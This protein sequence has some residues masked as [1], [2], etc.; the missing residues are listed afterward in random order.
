MPLLQKQ[1]EGTASVEAGQSELLLTNRLK[2]S[3]LA[4]GLL[5]RPETKNIDYQ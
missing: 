1:H 4:V 3:K 2:Y 5:K